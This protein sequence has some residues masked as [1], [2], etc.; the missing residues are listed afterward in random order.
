MGVKGVLRATIGKPL[1]LSSFDGLLL[2][3]LAFC[4]MIYDLFDQIA[5]LR[6]ACGE[7]DVVPHWTS[8]VDAKTGD[9]RR[10]PGPR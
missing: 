8:L 9:P 2:D 6:L 4:R 3:G 1:D 10:P 5:N 7:S